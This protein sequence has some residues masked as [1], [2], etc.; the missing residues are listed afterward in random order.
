MNETN[1]HFKLPYTKGYK[2]RSAE[3]NEQVVDAAAFRL[4]YKHRITL[5]T[6]V[7]FRFAEQ[8]FKIDGTLTQANTAS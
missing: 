7:A 6:G 2:N 5:N 3:I 8:R 4:W 1:S